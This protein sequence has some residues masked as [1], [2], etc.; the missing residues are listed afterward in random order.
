MAGLWITPDDLGNDL[1]ESEYAVEACEAASYL[2][3]AMSGRKFTGTTVV[4]ELYEFNTP[5]QILPGTHYTMSDIRSALVGLPLD[6][7][8][9]DRR[10]LRLRAAPVTR[11]DHIRRVSSDTYLDQSEYYI[12]NH[13]V[14][15]FRAPISDVLE[16]TYA[17]GQKPP[18]AGKMA[19]RAMAEQFALLWGGRADECKLPDRVTSVSRLGTTWTILDNQDFIAD[20]R[21]G[22]YTVDLFLKTA[23]PNGAQQR[24]KVFS[25]DVPRGRRVTGPT[26]N[27]DAELPP[28]P[29]SWVEDPDNPGFF[30][31]P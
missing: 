21:T 11:I 23:N 31:Q 24:S 10:R 22:I 4:T 8:N 7:V 9:G 19:A 2:L 26:T 25:P 17:Y 30:F 29:D 3:W 6:R 18:A 13:S 15:N 14:V 5:A 28:V 12:T 1:A 27:T 16:I 20:L